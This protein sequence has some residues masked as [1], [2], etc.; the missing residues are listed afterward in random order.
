MNG[1]AATALD[2]WQ[3]KERMTHSDSNSM[4]WLVRLV[5]KLKGAE[6]ERSLFQGSSSG[7]ADEEFLGYEALSS[8]S[9]SKGTSDADGKSSRSARSG[10]GGKVIPMPKVV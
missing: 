2:A 10:V 5:M 3:C 1:F 4:R 8:E 6:N 7:R 9:F